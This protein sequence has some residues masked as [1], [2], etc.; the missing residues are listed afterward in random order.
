[1]ATFLVTFTFVAIAMILMAVGVI[2]SDRK[3][4]GSCGGNGGDDC[5]CE[6]E[7]RRA[8]HAHKEMLRRKLE[9]DD[10]QVVLATHSVAPVETGAVDR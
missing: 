10:V 4:K 7:K 5:V 9:R 8:C 2:F 3:L 6:I 1:M